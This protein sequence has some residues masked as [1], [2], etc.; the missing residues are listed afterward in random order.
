VTRLVHR[1][2]PS[3]TAR[4]LWHVL[5]LG[6]GVDALP[7]ELVAEQVRAA[8]EAFPVTFCANVLGSG[9]V[10]ETLR[11]SHYF[12]LLV[13][14]GLVLDAVSLWSLS[15][16]KQDR[17]AGWKVVDGRAKIIDTARISLLTSF[18]WNLLLGIALL[19]P[20]P[21]QKLFVICVVTGSVCVGALT[22]ATVPLASIAFI[23]GSASVMFFDI[24]LATGLPSATYLMLCIFFLLLGRSIISQA[25]LFVANFKVGGELIEAS[26]DRELFAATARAESERAELAEARSQ[27]RQRE[28]AIETRRVDMMALGEKFERSVVEAAAV[29]AEAA[30]QNQA[31]A[32]ALDRMVASQVTRAGVIKTRTQNTSAAAQTLLGTANTLTSSV[33]QVTRRVAEQAALTDAADRRSRDSEQTIAALVA[34]AS[35]IGAIV[36]LI[37]DVASQTNLLAL[38][39]T[40]EAARAGEAG[41]GFAVVA[42]EV[43]SLAMQTQRAAGDIARQIAEMQ[44]HVGAAAATAVE[45]AEHVH[46]VA[47]LGEDIDLA[48]ATQREITG[49]IGA[50]AV[51]A[52]EGAADL[53]GAV[54]EA[55]KASDG[56][57]ALASGMAEATAGLVARTQELA[58][59]TQAFL[60]DLRAA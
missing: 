59:T 28:M 38:N 14:A 12:M 43:K 6:R 31:A 15:R 41:R 45:I 39:A 20:D 34:H 7:A 49:S 46:G 40:I 1:L 19:D 25:R 17:D 21:H 26:R 23:A 27:Q 60:V 47:R 32:D 52:A 16:W 50:D 22:V 57:R 30:R 29:L 54:E 11:H 10:I 18:A 44:G 42:T 37:G 51:M 48:M 13:M 33:S 3:T 4:S 24:Q 5:G 56:T 9:I 53:R 36:A 8:R 35:D 2:V 55:A 58:A